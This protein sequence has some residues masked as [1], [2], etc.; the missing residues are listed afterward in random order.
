MGWII[1]L[2]ASGITG[3]VRREVQLHEV[4]PSGTTGDREG[5]KGQPRDVVVP[6]GKTADK[7]KKKVTFLLRTD[8]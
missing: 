8:E 1:G 6:G 7:K 3:R 5:K 2:V 4:G